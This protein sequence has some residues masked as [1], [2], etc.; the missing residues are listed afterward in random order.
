MSDNKN[1]VVM[2]EIDNYGKIDIELYPEIAPNTVNNFIS[3]VKSGFYDGVIFHRVITNFMI[4]GGDPTGTGMGG[5]GYHIK[6]EFTENGFKNDLRHVP[7]VISMARAMDKDSA[8]SQ[9]FIMHGD[10][11]FLDGQYAA[12]GKVIEGM[13]V[14]NA[15]AT[16]EV[17]NPFSQSPRPTE[18]VVITK[19][20]VD[21]KG[22]E[23][24]EP[25]KV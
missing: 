2:M 6:G 3:L 19:A 7:G 16:C 14:V 5:P 18:P 21:T 10:A 11:A 4:Q 24:P 23:Y 1:P 8:G 17:E 25:E 22:I 12:F 9:F 13:D 20:V 15:I